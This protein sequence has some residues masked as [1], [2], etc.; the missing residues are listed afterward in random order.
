MDRYSN[1]T[2]LKYFTA[3]ILHFIH[4]CH[5]H[6]TQQGM[7]SSLSTQELLKAEAYW[8]LFLQEEH[9][10]KEIRM[11][12]TDHVLP[13]SILYSLFA[14]SWTQPECFVSVAGSEIPDFVILLNILPSSM[15][16]IQSLNCYPSAPAPCR[17]HAPYCITL[18][19]LTSLDSTR[20]F[21]PSLVDVSYR[22]V[23]CCATGRACALRYIT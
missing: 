21:V 17:T 22:K 19:S 8:L 2:Q 10:V 12:K 18:S 3:W 5:L 11:L 1:F 13:T 14:P 7:Q 15:E 16:N 6:G 20:Q 23:W 4:N 9:F